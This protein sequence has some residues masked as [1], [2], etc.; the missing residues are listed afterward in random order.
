MPS[1]VRIRLSRNKEGERV[2]QIYVGSAAITKYT[3]LSEFN[4]KARLVLEALRPGEEVLCAYDLHATPATVQP[5]AAIQIE[6]SEVVAV[7]IAVTRGIRST[8]PRAASIWLTLGVLAFLA[9]LFFGW[10]AWLSLSR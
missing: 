9:L 10:R 6:F 2:A 3:S 4:L 7:P 1:H 8:S 5:I